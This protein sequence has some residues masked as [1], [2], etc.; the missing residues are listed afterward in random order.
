[1]RKKILRI[2][3]LKNGETPSSI[4]QLK[5]YNAIFCLEYNVNPKDIEAELRLYQLDNV[6]VEHPDPEEILYIMG[7]IIDFDKK[8]EQLKIG[9]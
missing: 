9:G 3:D 5:V 8:I 2:H 6:Q 7:K 1:M 4:K